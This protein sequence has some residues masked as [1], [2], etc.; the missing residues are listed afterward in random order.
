MEIY[1]YNPADH[2]DISNTPGGGQVDAYG[3]TWGK[4]FIFL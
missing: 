2:I 3:D 4:R 1:N